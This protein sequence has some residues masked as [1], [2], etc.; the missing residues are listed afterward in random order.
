VSVGDV[1]EG[2]ITNF[3][4]K[5]VN[6]P[7]PPGKWNV[8]KS[9]KGERVWWDITLYNYE[10]DG[11]LQLTIQLNPIGADLWSGGSMERCQGWIEEAAKEIYVQGAERGSPQGVYCISERKDGYFHFRFETRTTRAP[12]YWNYYDLYYSTSS[13]NRNQINNTKEL[14]KIAEDA[15]EA[16]LWGMKGRSGKLSNFTNLIK[17]SNNSSSLESIE[18]TDLNQS[19]SGYNSDKYKMNQTL[20]VAEKL[21]GSK[22]SDDYKKVANEYF[23]LK[24]EYG[25]IFVSLNPRTNR[26]D[27]WWW[28]TRN[29]LAKAQENS[30]KKCNEGSKHDCVEFIA[31]DDIVFSGPIENMIFVNGLI[32]EKK[33]LC[34]RATK[35]DGMSWE[36]KNSSWG[37]YVKVAFEM[38]LQL[39]ECRELTKRKPKKDT[40]DETMSSTKVEVNSLKD[41]LRE[42]KS[43]LD[44]GLIS[45]E[46]YDEKSSK[47]LDDF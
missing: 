32:T 12:L 38:D 24:N 47:I 45:Q 13:I 17:R 5:G 8:D 33:T 2:Q 20:L 28:S 6:I 7:L 16:I 22:Y 27:Y 3:K 23:P 14:K 39:K 40:S 34:M 10:D 42:L 15:M 9:E 18:T 19:S 41:K 36:G 35:T 30:R 29:T 21:F 37:N 44:E 25:S 43:M 1:L 31:N 11:E 46:Q 4:N 26:V